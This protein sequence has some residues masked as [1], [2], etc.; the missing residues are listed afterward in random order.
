[1]F[2]FVVCYLCIFLMLLCCICNW[3]YGCYAKTIIIKKSAVFW[4]ITR[5]R[6]VNNY[7]TTLSNTS[8]DRRFHQHRGGSL[9]SIIIKSLMMRAKVALLPDS[10]QLQI[11]FVE[12]LIY[13][14][15]KSF[16]LK[17]FYVSNCIVFVY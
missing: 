17:R 16:S 6:V 3:F 13:V 11:W 4:G 7:H 1:V 12:A 15:N 9:K 5:R 8:E 10:H 14:Q 2:S